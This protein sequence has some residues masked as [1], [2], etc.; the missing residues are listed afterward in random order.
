M[1]RRIPISLLVRLLLLLGAVGALAQGTFQ[2]LGFESANLPTV[3]PGQP[4]RL[5]SSLDAIPY[6]TGFLGTNQLTQIRHNDLTLGEASID[7]LGPYANFGYILDGQ[8]TVVLQPGRDPFSGINVGASISQA[9]LVP[10]DA[11]SLLF[12]ARIYG[13]FSMALGPWSLSPVVM[14]TGTNYT[15]YAANIPLSA[16][17]NIETLTITAL[18]GPNTADYFDAFSFSSAPTPEPGVSALCALGALVLGCWG[19]K[20]RR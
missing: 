1:R 7:I 14:G 17:G 16:V 19:S 5:A 2:N 20:R 8:Y 13:A 4:G 18:A 10:G 12:R 11:Q 3:P 15:L 9:G 6:W